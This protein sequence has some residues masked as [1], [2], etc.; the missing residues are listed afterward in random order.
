MTG[1]PLLVLVHGTRFDAR[2]WAGYDALVPG[3]DVVAVDLPGHG[4]RAGEPYTADAAVA[5]V[6]EA[7]NGGGNDDVANQAEPGD[8]AAADAEPGARDAARAG[9][10]RPVILCGHSL[11]GYVAADYAARHPG[12]LSGLVL[13]GA[14]AEPARHPALLRLYTGFAG[15]LPR[16]GAHRMARV[17]NAVMR[18]AGLPADSVPGVEGYAVLGQAWAAVVPGARAEW[19]AGVRCPVH[20]VAGQFDQ[21][22][23]DLGAYARACREPRVH[24]IPRATHLAPFTHCE[25]VAR[26]LREAV[27]E[28]V[29]RT[30]R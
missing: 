5:V 30:A 29:Q 21:M 17:T 24:V 11:G 15:L 22:R 14:T 6:A 8:R 1:R 10:G 18:R 28:A 12:R 20:L 7:V 23:L 4:R 27:A 13:I 9:L 26:V 2:A 19:L 3:A 16:V 25:H